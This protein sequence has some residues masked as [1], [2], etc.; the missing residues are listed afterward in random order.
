MKGK[1]KK[2]LAITNFNHIQNGYSRDEKKLHGCISKLIVLVFL[3]EKCILIKGC[4]YRQENYCIY[5]FSAVGSNLLT[6]MSA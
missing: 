3:S 4:I 5:I 2:Q 1:S 6:L